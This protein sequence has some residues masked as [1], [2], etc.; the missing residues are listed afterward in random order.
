MHEDKFYEQHLL[1]LGQL[2]YPNN[3]TA[4]KLNDHSDILTKHH[5]LQ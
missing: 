4:R 1:V 2:L 3:M 5:P